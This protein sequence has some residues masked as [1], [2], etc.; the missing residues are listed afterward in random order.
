MNSSGIHKTSVDDVIVLFIGQWKVI[1][2]QY[3]L[4]Q[5]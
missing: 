1:H 2:M 5:L 4:V 3:N